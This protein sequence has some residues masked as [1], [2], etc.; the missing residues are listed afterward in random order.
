VISPDSPCRT[1]LQFAR[2][3]PCGALRVERLTS[4]TLRERCRVCALARL[5]FA[6]AKACLRWAR[7]TTRFEGT[8]DG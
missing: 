7:E 8:N 3:K 6:S 2:I 4:K 1:A 5:R